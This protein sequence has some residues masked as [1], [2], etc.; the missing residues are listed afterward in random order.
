MTVR[1]L[2]TQPGCGSLRSYHVRSD[3]RTG[4]IHC[5]HQLWKLWNDPCYCLHCVHNP[6][7]QWIPLPTSRYLTAWTFSFLL[8]YTKICKST[9][10]SCGTSTAGCCTLGAFRNAGTVICNAN[11][12]AMMWSCQVAKRG[13]KQVEICFN[14]KC[15]GEKCITVAY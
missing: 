13:F 6:E 8:C 11:E 14:W 12:L 2:F 3:R 10:L 4:D 15:S 7:K 5:Q 9:V 1:L